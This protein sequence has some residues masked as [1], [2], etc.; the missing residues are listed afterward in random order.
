MVNN[1]ALDHSHACKSPG[2]H[3]FTPTYSIDCHLTWGLVT[4]SGEALDHSAEGGGAIP[5]VHVL[6]LWIY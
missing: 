1:E 6:C 4:S 3:Y 2:T 5:R